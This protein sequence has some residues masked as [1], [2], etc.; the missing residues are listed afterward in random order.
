MKNGFLALI[1][2]LAGSLMVERAQAGLLL[3]PII[4][5]ET[6]KMGTTSVSGTGVGMRVAYTM[7]GAWVGGEYDTVTLKDSASNSNKPV[8]LGASVGYDFPV[9]PL[10]VF[11]TYFVNTA[12]ESGGATVSGTGTKVGVSLTMLPLVSINIES[13]ARNFTK[14]KAGSIESTIDS[15][16]STT[17]ISVSLPFDL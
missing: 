8:D 16:L 17:G 9:L 15:K 5:Y 4:S 7:M 2:L 10:R 1:V 3:E 11:G 12:Y 14:M 13:I 6:G